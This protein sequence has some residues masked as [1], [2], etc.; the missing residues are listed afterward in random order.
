MSECAGRGAG[1][2]AVVWLRRA[3]AAARGGRAAGRAGSL[4]CAAAAAG[5]VGGDAGGADG[6]DGEAAGE[7]PPAP[8]PAPAAAA[9]SSDQDFKAIK[10]L[11]VLE[12]YDV[13]TK[14]DALSESLRQR[15]P[16]TQKPQPKQAGEPMTNGGN[17]VAAIAQLGFSACSGASGGL[18]GAACFGAGRRARCAEGAPGRKRA[19]KPRPNSEREQA[20]AREGPAE[21]AR[22]MEGLP[23]KWVENLRDM[24]PEEQERFMQNNE[25]FQKSASAAAGADPQNL[26]KMEQAVAERE[27]RGFARPESNAGADDSRAA[28][29]CPRARLCRSG[30]RCRQT[31]R[32]AINWPSGD[33][34]ENEPGR[35][36]RLR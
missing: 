35:R 2:R 10:D 23:P 3:R 14:M 11:G 19:G 9:A 36:S 8:V 21:R 6:V 30:R 28:R 4:A 22:G 33:A 20:A 18:G 16:Q 1:D 13:L 26:R 25:R 15:R 7:R 34:A 5:V 27:G 29:V 24:S 31:R 17:V 12:N 32:Q